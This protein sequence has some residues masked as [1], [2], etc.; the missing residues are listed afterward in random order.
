ML[1][2]VLKLIFPT[3]LQPTFLTLPRYYQHPSLR[4]PTLGIGQIKNKAKDNR[5]IYTIEGIFAGY[6]TKELK[7]GIYIIGRKKVIIR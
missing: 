5:R 7:P 3:Q 1:F 4:N 2:S 6:N